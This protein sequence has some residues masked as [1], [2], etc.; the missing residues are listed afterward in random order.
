MSQPESV[1]RERDRQL[2]LVA[3][4]FPEGALYQ[5]TVTA[6]GRRLFTYV[7]RGFERIFGDSPAELPADIG[8]LTR[9]IHPDDEP[10][11]A[12]AGERSHRD[13]AP[14]NHEVRIRTDGGGERWVSFRS[15]PRA[16]PNGDVV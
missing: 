12:A 14:F 4:N 15:Q 16:L 3:E 10:G 11:M 13:M 6:E 9:R 5:Y 1:L 2:H 7:G 8:W